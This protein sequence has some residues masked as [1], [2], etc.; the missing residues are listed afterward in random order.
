MTLRLHGRLA[1]GLYLP[2]QPKMLSAE[3]E[4]WRAGPEAAWLFLCEVRN[5]AAVRVVTGVSECG[6]WPSREPRESTAIEGPR[7]QVTPDDKAV[8]GC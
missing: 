1:S 6:L 2:V 4:G 5:H 8:S 7:R 3:S